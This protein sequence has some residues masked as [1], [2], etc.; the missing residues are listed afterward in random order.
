MRIYSKLTSCRARSEA[1]AGLM[2]ITGEANGP[3]VKVGVAITGASS[4]LTLS[5]T[6]EDADAPLELLADLTT[7]LYAKSAILA[8]LLSRA[9]TGEGMH[10]DVNLF[11]SQIASLAN[12]ASNY[13]IAGQEA[14]RQGT[15]H[16]RSVLSSS[17]TSP[18]SS[19]S[20]GARTD[21][22]S[23]VLAA[24]SC[25]TRSSRQRTASS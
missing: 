24:A 21:S 16:P 13:L 1:E 7:G 18:S 23:P 17:S 8:G 19:L 12:I 4:S 3:P 10:I 15:A 5:R 22:G 9:Q 6:P 20:L 2:H 11:E 25:P 14:T